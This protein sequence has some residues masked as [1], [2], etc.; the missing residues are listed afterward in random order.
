MG[1]YYFNKELV[2]ICDWIFVNAHPFFFNI[3]E[4]QKAVHWIK[5]SVNKLARVLETNN[6]KK[7]IVIKESGFPT[8]GQPHCSQERQE[9]FLTLMETT[10]LVFVYFQAFDQP[11]K[12]D[13]AVEPFWGL[14][15]SQRQPKRYIRMKR[16]Q[17]FLRS[18]L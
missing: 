5:K 16:G 17:L 6:C 8:A 1:D 10:D 13:G 12:Q 2:D 11:W 4:P 14:F 15:D 18:S 3:K 9:E 7:V